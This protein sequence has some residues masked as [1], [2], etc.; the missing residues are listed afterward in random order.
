MQRDLPLQVETQLLQSNFPI[1]RFGF[2]DVGWQ[3][4]LQNHPNQLTPCPAPPDDAH[5]G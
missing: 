2:G 1:G 4:F 3:S 5:C